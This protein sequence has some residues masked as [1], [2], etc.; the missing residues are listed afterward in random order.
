[1]SFYVTLPSHGADTESEYGK[2]TNSQCDFTINLKKPIDLPIN[3]YE[4]ALVEMTFKNFWSVNLGNFKLEDKYGNMI[5][6]ED[7]II[8]D[9]LKIKDL[10]RHLTEKF[11][12]IQYYSLLRYDP[13]IDQYNRTLEKRGDSEKHFVLTNFDLKKVNFICI[14]EHYISVYVP[15][16]LNLT[17]HGLFSQ[18][19]YQRS[20]DYNEFNGQKIPKLFD[21]QKLSTLIKQDDP[22]TIVFKGDGSKTT[23]ICMNYPSLKV[24][25][26]LFVYTN[27]IEDSHVGEEMAKLLRVI[28]VDSDFNNISGVSFDEGHYVSLENDYIDH[29]RMLVKDST[30]QSIKFLDRI[31]PVS[32]KLHF[33]SKK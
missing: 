12:Q 30:G 17:I 14:S 33:R 23:R 1:M 4:V 6:N 13:E 3:K 10:C 8:Y 11:A 18:L 15:T 28:Q 25:Q 29:I 16:S 20:E 32:Y 19:I 31:V 9:G 24:I 7:I 22:D 5:F 26:N 27:I 21:I 2:A